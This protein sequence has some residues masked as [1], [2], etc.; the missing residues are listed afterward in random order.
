MFV[1][2]GVLVVVGAIYTAVQVYEA[3]EQDRRTDGYYC[4]FEGV[5][6]LDRAP[7][8]GER[9]IDVKEQGW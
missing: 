1:I 6:P 8:T 4:T 2:L 5:G 3:R 9:C 7:Q